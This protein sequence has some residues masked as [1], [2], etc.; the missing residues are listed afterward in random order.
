MSATSKILSQK[1]F[2]QALRQEHNDVNATLSVDGFL[3]GLVGRQVAVVVSTTTVAGDTSTFTFSENFGSTPLYA[4]QCIY[5]DGTQTT[6]LTAT[7]IS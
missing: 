1:D 6:L 2:E 5:T 7:R 3:V 4:I